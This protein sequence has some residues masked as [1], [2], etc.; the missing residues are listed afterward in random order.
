[1]WSPGRNRYYIKGGLNA[2]SI[3][4]LDYEIDQFFFHDYSAIISTWM[5]FLKKTSYKSNIGH[6]IGCS[7]ESG[8]ESF[9]TSI[10]SLLSLKEHFVPVGNLTRG[11]GRKKKRKG[12][13]S[14][15]CCTWKHGNCGL[16]CLRKWKT[17]SC[18]EVRNMDRIIQLC[19]V[20][21][22]SFYEAVERERN[23]F[24]NCTR[25]LEKLLLFQI[26]A[27]IHNWHGIKFISY[28]YKVPHR[29]FI[30]VYVSISV[31]WAQNST[32]SLKVYHLSPF[33]SLS[34]NMFVST[35]CAT[36][37]FRIRY[38]RFELWLP[39]RMCQ[40]QFLLLKKKKLSFEYNI[41]KHHSFCLF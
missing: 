5:Q 28:I 33:L 11:H 9:V 6:F 41:L 39:F 38:H 27:Q 24:V 19:S 25:S 29:C 32:L 2:V 16:L 35:T 37:F 17:L 22:N 40:D 7:C 8:N 15:T 26:Q 13:I 34:Q 31:R 20:R 21:T 1:M 36:S 3:I 18:K 10:G 30:W 14:N 12:P 23:S 4:S